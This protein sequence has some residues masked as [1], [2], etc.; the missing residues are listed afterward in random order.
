MFYQRFRQLNQ[1]VSIKNF[2]TKHNWTSINRKFYYSFH[3]LFLKYK[4]SNWKTAG[5]KQKK[6]KKNKDECHTKAYIIESEIESLLSM[7]RGLW[8]EEN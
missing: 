1:G 4:L 2:S 3:F 8:Q 6:R 5:L 7:A